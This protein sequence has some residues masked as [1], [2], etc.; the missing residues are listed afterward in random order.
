METALNVVNETHDESDNGLAFG[1]R[2]LENLL[3]SDASPQPDFGNQDAW[4]RGLQCVGVFHYKHNRGMLSWKDE[5]TE[6][7]LTLM[8]GQLAESVTGSDQIVLAAREIWGKQ[9]GPWMGVVPG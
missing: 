6:V 2:I 1:E 3:A 4:G 8:I 5:Y 7:T 9:A